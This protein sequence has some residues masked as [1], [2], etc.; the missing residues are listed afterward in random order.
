M[1]LMEYNQTWPHSWW[2][3]SKLL[4]SG[5]NVTWT[6][7]HDITEILLKAA[8]NSINQTTFLMELCQTSL[9]LFWSFSDLSKK[10]PSWLEQGVNSIS[11]GYVFGSLF[12]GIIVYNY[13]WTVQMLP[14]FFCESERF[15]QFTDKM[16]QFSQKIHN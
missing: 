10:P 3:V 5:W 12:M 9:S 1:F 13:W 15:K 7:C 8:L 4:C 2:N 16:Q 6:D 14:P 11:C